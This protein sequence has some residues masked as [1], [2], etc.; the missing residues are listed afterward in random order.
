MG[1][2]LLYYHYVEIDDPKAVKIAQVDFCKKNNLTGRII[3]ASE[4]INGTLGGSNEATRAYIDWMNQQDNFKTMPFKTSPGGAECFPRLSIKIKNEIV[5]IGLDKKEFNFK[6][7]APHLSPEEFHQAIAQADENTLIIDNRNGYE[8]R[9]GTFKGSIIPPIKYFREFPEYID[10]H[11]DEFKDK[12][13]LMF[14][15]GGIRC[16]RAS[17][18]M[19]KKGINTVYQ[20]HGGIHEYLNK[21]PDGFFRGLNYVFDS[22][23]SIKTNDD[24]LGSCD[25]CQKPSEDFTNCLNA[26]CNSHFIGCP[27]CIEKHEGNC[28]AQCQQLIKDGIVKARVP[29]KKTYEHKTL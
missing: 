1:T 28:S 3:I 25:I 14:C 29:L 6:D 19:K 4:G 10:K 15:T 9:V 2:V 12:K 18:Y 21:Y 24:I 5:H 20:L 11:L 17:A 16:E 8:A 22:R 26:S 7:A 27:S 23:L 13:V